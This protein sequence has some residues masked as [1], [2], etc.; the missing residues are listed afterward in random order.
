V[1][2]G[3]TVKNAVYLKGLPWPA[4]ILEETAPAAEQDWR[5]Q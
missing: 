1:R 2:G 4:Q 3:R 5:Q